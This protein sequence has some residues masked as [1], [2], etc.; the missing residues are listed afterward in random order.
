M[1]DI[2]FLDL[3]TD[4]FGFKIGKSKCDNLTSACMK[5]L[6]KKGRQKGF[7]C[8][9]LDI[10]S[11]D[12]MSFK[13]TDDCELVLA[14][15]R[16][17]L[18]KSLS[19]YKT[20]R[21]LNIKGYRIENGVCRGDEPYLLSISRNISK[22]SR[23]AFDTNFPRGAAERMYTLWMKNSI[24]GKDADGVIIAREN[25]T[26]NP[27]GIVTHKIEKEQ[28]HIVLVGVERDH[29]NRGLATQMLDCACKIF[30][31]NKIELCSVRTQANNTTALRLYEKN[32]FYI[33]TITLVCHLWIK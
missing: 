24:S 7:K 26:Q 2:E 21:H 27:V 6:C 20:K 32:G 25:R 12:S 18:E 29:N 22:V 15:I 19:D 3:D 5:S 14:D 16:V 10:E 31:K 4:V 17:T 13:V 30:K 9:Y 23:F 8:I 11:N 33:S 1:S 28:G